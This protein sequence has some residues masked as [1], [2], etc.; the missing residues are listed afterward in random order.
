MEKNPEYQSGAKSKEQIFTEFISGFEG[1][2]G[3]KDGEVTLDE[4]IDYYGDVSMSIASDDYFAEMMEQCWMIME[5]ESLPLLKEKC[6]S[7]INTLRLRLQT[8]TK[9]NQTEFFLRKVYSQYNKSKSGYMNVSE[10]EAMILSLG[11]SIEKKYLSSV[12]KE[13]DK[14]SSGTIEFEEFCNFIVNSTFTK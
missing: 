1:A 13:F 4:F 3:N 14:N 12:F 7:L 9:S 6:L 5:D 10:L 2:K 8:L 11:I